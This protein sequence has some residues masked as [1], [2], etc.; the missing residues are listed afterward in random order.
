VVEQRLAALKLVETASDLDLAFQQLRAIG[1]KFLVA[2][3]D[4][5]PRFDPQASRAVFRTAGAAVY[6]TPTL[7]EA[8][9]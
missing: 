1:V 4:H 2:L 5:G 9:R 7:G 8:R 3:G 6:V